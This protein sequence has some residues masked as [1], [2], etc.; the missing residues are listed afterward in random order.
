MNARPP[1][2]DFDLIKLRGSSTK[3]Y[4]FE[5]R[6]FPP[7]FGEVGV[8]YIVELASFSGREV[9][10]Q[11]IMH[12]GVTDNLAR[13]F[14]PHPKAAL[15]TKHGANFVCVLEVPNEDAR[16][17]IYADLAWMIGRPW[18]QP[19]TRFCGGCRTHRFA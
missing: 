18:S 9:T 6:P 2:K 16:N 11:K 5:L 10:E 8:V 15:F 1:V 12:M 17:A 4:D 14:S 3:T 7:V 13:E 19:S